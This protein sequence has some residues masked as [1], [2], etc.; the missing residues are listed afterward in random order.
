M[1]MDAMDE[2]EDASLALDDNTCTT[3]TSS[4]SAVVAAAGAAMKATPSSSYGSGGAD[5]AG[6]VYPRRYDVSITYDKYWQTP[7]IWLFGYDEHNNPLPPASIFDDIISDY[8]KKTVT[9]EPHP[10]LGTPHASIH[11]CQHAAAMLRIIQ[12]LSECGRPPVVEQ[13]MF[14]FLKFMQSVMPTIE[15]DYTFDVQVCGK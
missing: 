3:T 2:M 8:A 13:Y 15:Y 4:T 12:A 5:V 11:P 7:R 14:I 1:D 6:I 9:I 10:H